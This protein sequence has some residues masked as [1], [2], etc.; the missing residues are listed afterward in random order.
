M[1]IILAS[2]YPKLWDMVVASAKKR[3][4]TKFGNESF[5][6]EPKVIRLIVN[7]VVQEVQRKKLDDDNAVA[8]DFKKLLRFE[9]ELGR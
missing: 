9:R 7:D 3:G 2:D 6:A 1:V 5:E 4:V 8:S